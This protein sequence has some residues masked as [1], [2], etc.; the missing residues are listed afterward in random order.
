VAPTANCPICR[1]SLTLTP[2][3]SFDSWICPAGHGLAATLSEFYEE[4]QEDEARRLWALARAGTAPASG[5]RPC[6]MCVRP[7]VAIVVPTDA[8]EAL[9]GEP[10]DMPDTG[11]VPVDVCT[12]DQV[13]WFDVAELD[14]FPDDL[15][16]AQPTPEQ[17]AALA[18]IRRTFGEAIVASMEAD[19]D[20][21]ERLI[22]RMGRSSRAFR[23]LAERTPAP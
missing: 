10:G 18:D 15:P 21:A 12:T 17:E 16:D 20:L 8:D 19:E 7:M 2:A 1:A 4:A 6:P 3:G 11:E 22:H 14:A 5:P 23:R 13:I 9:E